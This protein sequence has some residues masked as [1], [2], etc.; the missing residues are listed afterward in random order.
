MAPLLA[1]SPKGVRISARLV[2]SRSGRRRCRFEILEESIMVIALTMNGGQ[3]YLCS[4]IECSIPEP[5]SA[6]SYILCIVA[7][8]VK[9]QKSTLSH[10]AAEPHFFLLCFE[11]GLA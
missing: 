3:D 7:C 8:Q 6:F 11:R 9:K 2:P 4:R 10:F 5:S 1:V